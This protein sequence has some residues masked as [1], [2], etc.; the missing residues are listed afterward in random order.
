[1]NFKIVYLILLSCF[2]FEL[3][4]TEV[5]KKEQCSADPNFDQKAI[6]DNFLKNTYAKKYQEI[7]PPLVEKLVESTRDNLESVK[8][9]FSKTYER[10]KKIYP[11]LLLAAYESRTLPNTNGVNQTT[12][13]VVPEEE[14]KRKIEE[15]SYIEQAIS[16]IEKYEYD[17]YLNGVEIENS[18]GSYR[19]LPKIFSMKYLPKGYKMLE[20]E[21][22]RIK[23]G[24]AAC[25]EAKKNAAFCKDATNDEWKMEMLIQAANE[26]NKNMYIPL[27]KIPDN[28]LPEVEKSYFAQIHGIKYK[29]DCGLSAIDNVKKLEEEL[30]KTIYLIPQEL[31]QYLQK[32][33]SEKIAVLRSNYQE[34]ERLLEVYKD[35]YFQ[36]FDSVA[37]NEKYNEYREVNEKLKLLKRVSTALI[38]A[39]Q[40][41]LQP[42]KGQTHAE[43]FKTIVQDYKELSQFEHLNPYATTFE[44]VD[45]VMEQLN[46]DVSPLYY[47]VQNEKMDN[48][49]IKLVLDNMVDNGFNINWGSGANGSTPLMGAVIGCVKN[50][51]ESSCDIINHMVEKGADPSRLNNMGDNLL[52]MVFV[53]DPNHSR[54]KEKTTQVYSNQVLALNSMSENPKIDM[55][56]MINTP[57]SSGNTTIM[58][59]VLAGNLEA[60]KFLI[61]K[62]ADLSVKIEGRTMIDILKAKGGEWAKLVP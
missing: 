22:M 20:N 3:I 4:A 9:N 36:S 1:M 17:D 12:Q 2:S 58:F 39:A 55:K 45:D 15:I 33:A 18:I 19:D 24:F 31:K 47:L 62:G 8:K 34:K 48:Q 51:N 37:C 5:N 30:V 54:F 57:N 46:G 28:I 10:Y 25:A 7:V 59:S 52:N 50:F 13:A 41:Q 32:Q 6:V 14:R 61:E 35:I 29:Y 16:N 38:Q 42:K 40:G 43:L 60:T 53:V 23:K 49:N 21:I 56:K 11:P 27:N 26:M 44:N